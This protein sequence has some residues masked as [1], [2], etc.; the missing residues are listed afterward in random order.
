MADITRNIAQF[1]F[2]GDNNTYLNHADSTQLYRQIDENYPNGI[3]S[4]DLSSGTAFIDYMPI[5]QLGIQALPGTKFN[6]NTNLDPIIVG[7]S[8]MYELDL[9]NNSAKI[10]SLSFEQDSLDQITNNPDGYLIVDILY[11]GG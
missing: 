10:T 11:E 5:V 6:L 3:S 2:F 8:G 4:L 9:T 1:R 7:A